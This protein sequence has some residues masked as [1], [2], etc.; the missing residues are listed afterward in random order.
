MKIAAEL[1]PEIMEAMASGVSMEELHDELRILEVLIANER[2]KLS[3]DL[4]AE[5]EE[6]D[7][8]K[9]EP[10]IRLWFAFPERQL[11]YDSFSPGVTG[12]A[13][14]QVTGAASDVQEFFEK[15]DSLAW[16]NPTS[17]LRRKMTKEEAGEVVK[18]F[19]NGDR[20]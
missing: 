17:S 16:A 7:E 15:L 4:L 2:T 6:K 3:V 14:L 8:E 12:Y 13:R 19:I 1:F 18:R 9:K 10:P 11:E 20:E 5:R